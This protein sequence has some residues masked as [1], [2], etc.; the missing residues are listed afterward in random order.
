MRILKYYLEQRLRFIVG[1][2]D[3]FVLKFKLKTCD[4][5]ADIAFVFYF[6]LL[7]ASMMGAFQLKP[8]TSVY[9]LQELLIKYFLRKEKDIIVLI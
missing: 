8:P 6:W 1:N 7:L 4:F 9:L 3:R 5:S 2:N